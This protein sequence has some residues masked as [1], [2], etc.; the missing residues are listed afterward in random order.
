[1]A[2]E[3]LSESIPEN[4]EQGRCVPEPAFSRGCGP[5]PDSESVTCL[6]EQ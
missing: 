1:M 3:I 5:A 4:A 6:N 2:L